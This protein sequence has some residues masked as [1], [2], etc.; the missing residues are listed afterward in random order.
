MTNE[1]YTD[2][3][4]EQLLNSMPKQ[5]DLRAKEDVWNA[6]KQQSMAPKQKKSK[7]WLP[8]VITVAALF[9]LVLFVQSLLTTLDSTNMESATEMSLND[10]SEGSS[11]A[12]ENSG[13]TADSSAS[14]ATEESEEE[15]DA[16]SAKSF[17]MQ[18][19]PDAHLVF[20]EDPLLQTHTAVPFSLSYQAVAFPVTL[21]IPNER[22]QADFP[23]GFP[24]QLELYETYSNEIDELALGFDEYLPL[25]GTVVESERGLE[26][27]LPEDHPYDMASASSEVY[28][29][30]LQNLFSKNYS[31]AY[32]L[33]EEGQ[34]L[35]WDQ[36]GPLADPIELSATGLAYSP[37]QNAIGDDYLVPYP[38][39]SYDS[40][41]MAL[42]ELQAPQNSVVEPIL[43]SS[44]A[45]VLEETE[46]TVTFVFD[47][48]LTADSMPRR[49]L[50]VMLESLIA[51][52]ASFNKAV[53]FEN[54]DPAIY[55]VPEDT[56]S[57]V[58]V[59]KIVLPS[60]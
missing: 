39:T 55:P 37:L 45:Y 29:N 36:V 23:G 5:V 7:P 60:Q 32:L 56:R 50:I 34:P 20:S 38:R 46:D 15:A 22:I 2:H 52:A 47:Q 44:I 54:W 6:I 57:L 24:S 4:V 48:T 21:L 35:E 31:Q 10:M 8:A 51:T 17:S 27:T 40:F 14:M 11:G 59:N 43:P 49:D 1:K 25:Q 18:F 41:E 33:D 53:V 30:S 58:G 26:I 9:V 42:N 3:D 16:E 12:T 13:E 28:F 19:A